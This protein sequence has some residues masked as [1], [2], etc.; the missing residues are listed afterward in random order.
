M[1]LK[2]HFLSVSSERDFFNKKI[3]GKNPFFLIAGPCVIESKELLANVCEKIKKITDELGI[4]YVFKS[5]FDKANRTSL[6]SKRGPGLEEGL[7]LLEWI[8]KEFDVLVLTDVHE[9]NQVQAVSQVVDILQI[10]AFLCRQTDLVVECAKTNKWINVKKGQFLAPW[11]V[12]S[13]IEKVYAV[14]NKNLLLTERGVSFG[15]NNL[16]F[17]PRSIPIMHSFDVPVVID[18]THSTQLPGGMGNQSGGNRE[19]A[20]YILKSAVAIGVEGIFMEVHPEPEKAWSDSATQYWLD[21]TPDLL[22]QLYELDRLV[23]S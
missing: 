5:S 23:K 21:K 7:K 20:P 2:E 8:K 19:L 12:K 4:L 22:K 16:V 13:I 17:D 3:G 11:D 6:N 10:P 1:K 14:G 18:G 9:T 15:Y